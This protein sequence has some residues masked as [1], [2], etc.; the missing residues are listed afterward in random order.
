MESKKVLFIDACISTGEYSRTAALCEHLLKECQKRMKNITIETV[1][2]NENNVHAFNEQML[3]ERNKCIADND[4][5]SSMFDLAKQ[6]KEADYI[7]VGAPYW[8]F[9]FPTLLKAYIEDI[10]VTNLTF[11]Y[12]DNGVVGLC[13]AEKLVYVTS[14]GGYI[15]EQNL[16]FDYIEA[17]S[18]NMLGIPEVKFVSAEGLDIVGC[19]VDKIMGDAKA[20]IDRRI[21]EL[22]I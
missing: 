11:K 15:G 2:L 17:L 5:S 18:I 14:A 6:F 4:Y 22:I 1:K 21:E 19:N 16:G 10:M 9:S 20:E 12:T 13:N 8:D 3:E 7:I